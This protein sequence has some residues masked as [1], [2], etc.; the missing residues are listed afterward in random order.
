M[1]AE[2]SVIIPA[3]NEEHYIR[4]PMEGLAKQTFKDFETIVVDGNSSD[5]TRQMAKKFAKVI[6]EKERGISRARNAGAREARGSILLFLDADTRPSP[7]LLS[8]YRKAF[9]D[10][11]VVIATGPIYPIEK[12]RKRIRWGYKLVSVFYVKAGILLHRPPLV[13][14]NI[15]VR[16]SAFE[17]VRGFDESLKSHED[18][19]LAY[20][21]SRLGRVAY[22]NDAIVHTS[23][24]R[25]Q[26]WGVLKFLKFKVKD[27]ALYRFFGRAQ[28]NYHTR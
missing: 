16:R 22:L 25:L 27:M 21:I 8:A 2:I 10:D 6:V 7:K 3:R 20:R 24:R 19:D 26:E 1:A 4:Y 15:A 17:K 11:R 28:D 13:G 14:A 9:K 18:F 23:A 5:R 12:T